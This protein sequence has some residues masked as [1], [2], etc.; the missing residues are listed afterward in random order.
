MSQIPTFSEP[1]TAPLAEE[2]RAAALAFLPDATEIATVA[3]HPALARVSA[4]SG[5]WRVQQWPA[6][7]PAND[8]VAVHEVMDAARKAGLATVP[9]LLPHGDASGGTILRNEQRLYDA[10]RW[11]PGEPPARAET[12]WPEAADRID[13]PVALPPETLSAVMLFLATLHETTADLASAPGIPAAPLQH[14]PGAV[15]QAQGRHL[16]TLRAR[17][18]HEPAIQ[19]WLAIG[20]RL[21]AAAEPAVLEA[22]AANTAQPRLLHLGLWPA[23]VLIDGDLLSGVLGW[24]RVS[25]GSPLLDIAQAILRLQGWSEESA[26][27]ALG[28]YGDVHRLTP[29]ERRLL[30][31]I[32]ALDAVAT[33]GRLLEQTFAGGSTARPP[34]ALRDGIEMM[35]RSMTALDRNLNAPSEKDR[36]RKWVRKGPPARP[37]GGKRRE[38]RS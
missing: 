17:S 27:F 13:L 34:S 7:T 25:A 3:G 11:L 29:D 9:A 14:L 36:R 23:H 1:E 22:A 32:A 19:R 16:G 20:E 21:L 12:W 37:Q 31:A 26:E 5:V 24:E 18:R 30:P 2:L 10:Q 8:V 15:R 4:P 28:A 6:G 33:T 38:R 35:L